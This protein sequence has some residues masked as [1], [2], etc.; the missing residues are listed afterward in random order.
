MQ[1][2]L[3]D[4]KNISFSYNHE[5]TI[6]EGI[7]FK[8]FIGDF[9]G[10]LGPNGGGKSTLLGLILAQMTPNKG[11]YF[12]AGKEVTKTYQLNYAQIA[13]VPQ[14][15]QINQTIPMT[16][17][18][19]LEQSAPFDSSLL[20]KL[21]KDFQL[22]DKINFLFRDLSGGQKQKVLLIRAL[23]KKPQLLILDE[24]RT[25]IDGHAEDELFGHLRQLKKQQNCAVIMVE[26]NL[27]RLTQ[28]CNH[29]L[30]LNK[31]SHWHNKT[32]L[33]TKE[34]IESIYHCEF[35]HLLIHKHDPNVPHSECSHEHAK[36]NKK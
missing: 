19:V 35:E 23:L 25:G 9:L 24:P 13:Y 1:T 36:E 31:T 4:L 21:L 29:I 28:L 17:N 22:G 15:Q 5:Q 26:H 8:L 14:F 10:V 33:L 27:N 16:V 20:A 18:E 2:P 6:L 3:V 34:V 12:F 11:Q 32:E 30:C 7:N